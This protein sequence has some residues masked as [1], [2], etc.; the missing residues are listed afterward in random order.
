MSYLA[1][2]G[3][4]A[5]KSAVPSTVR[6]LPSE[7]G[8]SR[9]QEANC[10]NMS[11]FSTLRFS[12]VCGASELKF[13]RQKRITTGCLSLESHVTASHRKNVIQG[14]ALES[15]PLYLPNP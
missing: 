11:Q 9:S 6:R 13:G 14:G 3:R 4:M 7:Y 2:N 8:K 12:E 10:R 5:V 1:R 15:R